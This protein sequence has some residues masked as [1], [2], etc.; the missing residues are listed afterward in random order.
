MTFTGEIKLTGDTTIKDA[1][2]NK[3]DKKNNKVAGKVVKGKFEYTG[4]NENAL[5]F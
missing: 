4:P 2:F 5:I 3:V 1:V